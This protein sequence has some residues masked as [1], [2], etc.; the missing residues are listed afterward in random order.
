MLDVPKGLEAAPPKPLNGAGALPGV[1]KAG[2]LAAV[3]KLKAGVLAAVPPKAGVLAP[4]KPNAELLAAPKAGA[5]KPA[6]S[7]VVAAGWLCGGADALA[8]LKAD[9]EAPN[10]PA[11]A[12]GFHVE[13][14]FGTTISS[15]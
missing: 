2:A 1:P 3:L 11:G 5:L 6:K 10:R 15:G 9:D 7:E 4:P 12:L 8:K 13:M 14:K